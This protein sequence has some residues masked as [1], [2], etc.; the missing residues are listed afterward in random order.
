MRTVYIILNLVVL[1]VILVKINDINCN[2]SKD[3]GLVNYKNFEIERTIID[4]Q[5]ITVNKTII[6]K[7]DTIF[8]DTTIYKDVPYL[9]TA[10]MA[11]VLKEYYA[12]KVF[13]D[14]IRIDSSKVYITDTIQM[15]KILGRSVTL[16][17]KYP[18]ISKEVF[19]VEKKKGSVYAGGNFNTGLKAVSVGLMYQTP[20]SFMYGTS[21]GL[22]DKKIFYGFSLYKKL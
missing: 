4:T 17:M 7:G 2:T 11:C 18:S 19:Y 22:S 8:K 15:N 21:L 5:Y 13:K 10:E 14:T 9:D 16:D 12:Q 1:F 20:K 6:K 3:K